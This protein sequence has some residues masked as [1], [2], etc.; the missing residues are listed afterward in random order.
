M[1]D[2]NRV[3]NIIRETIIEILSSEIAK[4]IIKRMTIKQKILVIYGPGQLGFDDGVK[5]LKHLK[6][7][8]YEIDI[9]LPMYAK[10][11]FNKEQLGYISELGTLR[12]ESQALINKSDVLILPNVDVSDVS[13]IANCI[14][15]NFL[16]RAASYFIQTSKRVIASTNNC[17]P[18]DQER[19]DLQASVMNESYARQMTKHM[20]MM[21]SYG[22]TFSYSKNLHRKV[23]KSRSNQDVKRYY[24]D[25]RFL[26]H[27]DLTSYP[28]GSR[29]EVENFCKLTDI[30]KETLNKKKMSLIVRT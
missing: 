10:Q 5:A 18:K 7:E 26:T 9:V 25:K 8:G 11:Y 16:T 17:C 1:I 22:I 13:K 30:A 6:T 23:I 3:E 28:D 19:L 2:K 27:A 20:E 21:A 15:D 24:S 14:G 12:Q 29:L 4:E